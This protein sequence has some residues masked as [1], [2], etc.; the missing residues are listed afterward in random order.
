M[1]QMGPE[2]EM[3]Q[4]MEALQEIVND[5]GGI[6]SRQHIDN[7][8]KWM[9]EAQGFDVRIVYVCVVNATENNEILTD[10]MNTGGW[11]CLAKWLEFFM[12]TDKHAAIRE[13]L[14]CFKRLPVSNKTLNREVG[15]NQKPGKMIKILKKHED[16]DIKLLAEEIFEQW[17]KINKDAEARKAAK[18]TEKRKQEI[19]AEKEKLKK[20][21]ASGPTLTNGFM[22]NVFLSEEQK[23]E[24]K[25]DDKEKKKLKKKKKI[26][27]IMRE[28]AKKRNQTTNFTGDLAILNLM[29]GKNDED[30]EGSVSELQQLA[31]NRSPPMHQSRGASSSSP[32]PVSD[33][34]KRERK[35][36]AKQVRWV[37]QTAQRPLEQVREIE[38]FFGERGLSSWVGLVADLY[39][40]TVCFY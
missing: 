10:F 16:G 3:M 9:T 26:E 1:V 19:K 15:T 39:L 7:L 6:D 2:K 17:V 38:I 23:K 4:A 28:S 33:F 40:F 20:M 29:G 35:P 36:G 31:G 5:K 22:D 24:K 37:D 30:G 25:R 14:K 32:P 13:I 27:E 12:T 34:P 8:I 21:K 11:N 18:K